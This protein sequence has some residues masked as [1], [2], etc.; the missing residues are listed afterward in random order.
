MLVKIEII[1]TVLDKANKVSLIMWL[2]K[3]FD[4]WRLLQ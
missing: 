3:E 1:A 2:I 4:N